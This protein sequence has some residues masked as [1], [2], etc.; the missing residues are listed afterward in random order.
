MKITMIAIGSTGDVRPYMLLGQEL[1]ERGHEVTIAAFAPFETMIQEAG[2][3]FYPLSG[4]IVDL[5]G[6]LLQPDAVG[7]SYLVEFEK[8]IRDIAPVL[9]DDLLHCADGAEALVCTFFGSMFY[10]IAEKYDIP[11]IQT[12]YFP[13]DP[14]SD[15]PISSAPFRKLGKWW[16]V[17]SYRIG[18]LLISTLE[19]RYL[20]TWRKENDMRRRH[21]CAR[22][23]YVSS[24]QTVPVIYA[25]S[26]SLVPR[27]KA[28]RDNI[29][30]SGFW[31]NEH[32]QPYTP[33]AELKAF[34]Q[35][36][37]KPVYIGFG[38]M[39]SGDM[40]ELSQI[41]QEAVALS[42]VRAVVALGWGQKEA[43]VP[44]EH[45]FYVDSVPHDWLFPRMAGAVHHGGA[46]TTA[47]SLRHGLPTLIV[48]FG[49][50]Q[51]F[52]G[53]RVFAAGCGPR[54]IPREKL[55]AE[56]LAESLSLLLHTPEYVASA[57][58]IGEKLRH[59]HGCATAADLIEKAVLDWRNE[60]S[61]AS[62][63]KR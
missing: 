42:G 4:D 49:G 7:V 58:R 8:G 52:W 38:S 21:V 62:G 34:L 45:I 32:V 39:V 16:N 29:H 5:M 15:M 14:C 1:H 9:L 48:P 24:G 18:Y 25:I 54:P 41:I 19:H 13:M 43:A 50:D 44:N 61:G 33:S 30:M 10:S 35:A 47:S 22:P 27:P 57:A 59:E 6:R 28:W 26:P 60:T 2:L 63:Q 3:S 31:W 12:Q 36:G 53:D 11:C 40:T 20:S 37:E 51:P 23:D 46:G 55:T 56:L 17:L